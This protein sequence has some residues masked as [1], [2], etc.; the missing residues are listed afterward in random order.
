MST[1]DRGVDVIVATPGRV[2]DLLKRGTLNLSKVKFAIMAEADQMLNV[3]FAKDV[4]TILEYLPK[5][6]Y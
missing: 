2:I 6:R 1:L 5:Q 3:G 4:E